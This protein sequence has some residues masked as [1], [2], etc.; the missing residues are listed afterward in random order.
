MTEAAQFS[1]TSFSRD[2]WKAFLARQ[3]RAQAWSWFAAALL[4]LVS[5]LLL[6]SSVRDLRS[7]YLRNSRKNNSFHFYNLICYSKF[8]VILLFEGPLNYASSSRESLHPS[9]SEATL[10]SDCRTDPQLKRN[11]GTTFSCIRVNAITRD[12]CFIQ[13]LQKCSTFFRIFSYYPSSTHL[14]IEVPHRAS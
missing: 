2:L 4:R 11:E 7:T 1:R 5:A 9:G 10:N 12:Q 13:T 14:K 3:A 8:N 6:T